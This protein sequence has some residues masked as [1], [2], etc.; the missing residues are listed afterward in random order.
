[1]AGLFRRE[2]F[3]ARHAAAFGEVA[4]R[5][6]L[7]FAVWCVGAAVIAAALVALL[8]FGQYTRRARIQGVTV[9]SAGVLKLA[10]T[11]PGIVVER[12]VEEGQRVRAGDVLFVVLS[13]RMTET[14]GR[15]AGAHD[16]ILEQLAR[17]RALLVDEAGRR[18]RLL[19]QQEQSLSRRLATL[20]LEVGQLRAEM[21]TQERREASARAQSERFERL[22][23][24]GFVSAAI[25]HQRR[26]ELLEQTARRQALF[27]SLLV[28]RREIDAVA[29]ELKQLP[30]RA[31]QQHAEVE[32][33][34]AL[35][36]Q[37]IVS[38]E[39][40]RKSVVSAPQDGVVTAI[41]AEPGQPVGTQPLATLL[42]SA[43]PMEAHL[44]APSRAVGFVEP[45]Q[46]VRIRFAAYPFQ[47]FGQYDGAV[48]H[49]SRVALAQSELPAQVVA[50]SPEPL[51]RVTVRQCAAAQ[52]GDATGS[53]RAAGAAPA[54]RVGVRTA[55]RDRPEGVN[56]IRTRRSTPAG[57]LRGSSRRNASGRRR[58]RRVPSP[59]YASP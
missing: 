17:R 30:L 5:P 25:A 48:V 6:P 53:G 51:Y 40:A 57:W 49:V 37:D 10:P 35:L 19:E 58:S 22:E 14:A 50:G 9:P 20:A 42:P 18:A 21:T 29:A 27:R 54:D 46:R 11:Q 45:G 52:R 8:V 23:Q 4:T 36:Q 32:R 44:F 2:V 26:D 56:P 24:Q 12:R 7:T 33:E 13:E 43:S 3:E 41:A 34:L 47:K 38:A 55:D 16:A 59:S 15:G 39:A 31:Q 1:M 28:V